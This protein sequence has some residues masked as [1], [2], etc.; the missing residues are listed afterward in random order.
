M[1][2]SPLKNTT[3]PLDLRMQS[4]G[5]KVVKIFTINVKQEQ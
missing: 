5:E 1:K 2:I 4:P 3:V